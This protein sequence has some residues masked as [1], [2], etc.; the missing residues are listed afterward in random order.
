MN[1]IGLLG[2]ACEAF[3]EPRCAN[4][5]ARE[6]TIVEQSE[7]FHHGGNAEA[8]L[9]ALLESMDA[10][11]ITLSLEFQILTW[12]K[13][14]VQLF[15]YTSEEAVG[16]P[17]TALFAREWSGASA[18]F[19]HDVE[20]FRSIGRSIR[21]FEQILLR[22]DG[23]AIEA[24]LIV[25]PIYDTAGNLTGVSLV[26]RDI[27]E[28]HRREREMAHLAA[29]VESSD[30]AIISFGTDLVITSWNYG[31]EKLL[32]FTRVEASGKTILD[33]NVPPAMR[34]Q[35]HGR[36]AEDLEAFKRNPQFVRHL[37]V[38]VLHIDGRQIEVSL[39]A[40]GVRDHSGQLIGISV[41]MRDITESR[42]TDR[43]RAMLASIVNASEDAIIGFSKDQIITY[44]NSGA[45]R[46][47]GYTAQQAI[48][49]G[50]DLIIPPEQQEQAA[51]RSRRLFAAGEP[52]SWEE[53]TRRGDGR[54][55]A[56]SM[57]IFPIRDA[58]RNIIS[59]AGI[60]RDITRLKEVE[61]QL[62]EAHEYTRGLIESSIDAMIV[63]DSKMLITDCNEQLA[64]LT[65][66]PK[67]ELI[68]SPFDSYFAD[69]SAAR[70]AIR[71]V[72]TDGYATNIDL[73]LK[74]ASG[75]E[76]PVSF[77]ASLFYLAGQVFGIVGVARDVTEQRAAER[78]LREQREYSRG[79]MQSAPD[80]MLVCNSELILTDANDQASALTGYS[81]EELLG[82]N[83]LSLFSE[84]T[85]ANRQITPWQ[86]GGIHDVE[87]ELLTKAAGK[88]AVSLNISAFSGSDPDNRHIIV[89]MRDISERKRAEQERSLLAA[90]VNSSGDAIYSE[91]SNLVITSWNPAAEKLYGYSS[92]EIIGRSAA[93]LVPLDRRAELVECARKVH[94]T[95]KAQVFESKQV[96]R[97]GSLID[98]I[99]TQSPVC[100][101]TGVVTGIS[102][103]AHDISDQKCLE[104]EL[105][106]ARDAAL[107]GARAESEFLAHMS[108]EIRTPLNSI[109]GLTGLLLDTSL[110]PQQ[111]ECVRDLRATGDALLNLINDILDFSEMAAGKLL[112][113]E[114]DFD[115]GAVVEETAE[116]IAAQAR[117]KGLELT[118]TI[119]PEVP[120][121]L[122]GDRRRLRQILYNLLSN[123][124]K[125]TEHGEVGVAVTK[126]GENLHE[127]LLR[128]EVH[129]TGLG[130]AAERQYLLF[131]RFTQLD[132][133]TMRHYG[134]TG[135]GLPI[136]RTLVEAM[137][138][139]VAVSSRLGEGSTFW[140]TITLARQPD[141]GS[142]PADQF[143][144]LTASRSY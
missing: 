23:A 97:D 40:S 71:R 127:A 73:L 63:V 74:A 117:H 52:V 110:T 33:L 6:C 39:A 142:P 38:P 66:I 76:V 131:Q 56:S 108:H 35:L 13:A 111:H 25:A 4:L 106:R 53:Y 84:P 20:N 54:W 122:R 82:I 100:D 137:H 135:L 5:L 80:A 126:L 113:D 8:H 75:K 139:T 95:G 49:H 92:A 118:C 93:L 85:H 143:V 107:E 31:A 36:R 1:V 50:L 30:D 41:I 134:G 44:W 102:V 64:R 114:L 19:F 88:V 70:S 116:M 26:V 86:Q 103:T 105:E 124:V 12:N 96:R 46:I 67:K 115:L 132:H 37:E 87:L 34:E 21:H 109:I 28:R 136:V 51:E 43:E 83:L 57:S 123:A 17:P 68:A 121:L 48:G 69:R 62:R 55:F 99:I 91:S 10:A 129:D 72:F 112:L 2:V 94:A 130:I 60:G 24:A 3:G 89:S 120:R 90:I 11:I 9:A 98:V 125:F 45:Q 61:R 140:F 15:D 58:D 78:I 138:G 81:R 14:A 27:S 59:S 133:S 18:E 65:T 29:I 7:P 101:V 22:K 16:R 141:T 32:G 104:A 42:R 47:Y 79:L 128:F 144:P 77:N 119:D